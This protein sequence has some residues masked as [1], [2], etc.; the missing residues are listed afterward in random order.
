MRQNRRELLKSASWL[1]TLP[2]FSVAKA[3]PSSAAPESADESQLQEAAVDF[4]VE[5]GYRR[6]PAMHLITGETFN[7]GLRF[8]DTPNRTPPGK[9]V[10]LQ[11]CGRTGDLAKR[12]EPGVLPYFHI[13]ALC[14]ENPDAR[15]E[16]FTQVLD[17]LVESAELDPKRLALVSTER[18]IPY[19][20]QLEPYGI[21]R[22][23]FVQRD[24]QEAR[25]AG[26]G[27]G[28]FHPKGHPTAAGEYTV[29]IHYALEDDPKRSERTL[30]YPLNGYL[31]LAEVVIDGDASASI[32]RE[33]GGFG[34]ER[35]LM[36]QG[37][38]I[39]G[40]PQSQQKAL[41]AIKAESERR[42]LALPMA[43]QKIRNA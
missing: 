43:Y 38:P 27:S 34:L 4:F 42:G 1:M 15:G 40:F 30:E 7:D 17:Y 2:L 16:L 13:V 23:Q 3:R 28:Y 37:K 39:D 25:A 26:D 36:A 29:S 9:T 12:G 41:S 19:L 20:E 31:E 6:L 8:D 14:I 5:R 21:R 24:L 11:D 10:R 35:V 32:R 22:E 33:S 18:F